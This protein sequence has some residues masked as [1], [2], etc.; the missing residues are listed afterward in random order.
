MKHNVSLQEPQ[1]EVPVIYHKK[2]LTKDEISKS[3][4][5]GLNLSQIQAVTHYEGPCMVLA[6]PGSGKTLTIAKR[7]EYLMC[8]HRVRPEEI[9]VITFTK[10]ASREMKNRLLNICGKAALPVTCGTFHGIYYGILKWAYRLNQ[11]N[12]LSE[13][14]K[15]ALIKQACGKQE[16]SDILQGEEET[17]Y[18][19]ELAEEIGNVKNNCQNIDTYESV[20][21]GVQRFREIY[22]A[23]EERKKKPAKD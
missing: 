7:I 21:Y 11:S 20:R 1:T 5:R 17:E 16:F 6:G 3:I 23:Y 18:L 9:L 8:V 14:E 19:K 2:D 13:Q 22:K 4:C 10:Y 15:Y 12:L